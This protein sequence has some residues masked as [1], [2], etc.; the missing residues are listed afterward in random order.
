MSEQQHNDTLAN[1][2]NTGINSQGN[3]SVSLTGDIGDNY[4]LAD[5]RDDMDFYHFQGGEGDRIEWKITADGFPWYL[6]DLVFGGV[7]YNA[8]GN[9]IQSS[10][11][12]GSGTY[13]FILPSNGLYYLAVWGGLGRPSSGTFA[14]VDPNLFPRSIGNAVRTGT[15]TLSLNLFDNTPNYPSPAP[16]SVTLAVSPTSVTEDGTPNLVYTFTRSGSTTNTLAVNYTIGGTATNGSD[17]TNIGTSVTFAAGSSTATVTVAPTADTTVENDE[18]VILT[19]AS[20]TGYTVGST[21]AVTGTITNDDVAALPSIS[22][23]VS[24][25]SVQEDGTSNLVYTFTRTGATTSAITANYTVGGT[26]TLGTDYTGISSSSTTKTVSFA[27]GSTTAI[28]TVDPTADTTVESDETVTLTLASGTGYTVGTTGAVTGT[29][30]NDDNVTL[31][32]ITLGVNPASVQEDGTANLV[33]TFSRTGATTSALTVNYSIAGTADATDYTGATPGTGKTIA[34]AAGSSTT[35]V[36]ID[37]TADATLESNE[38]VALTLAT[39]TGYT[40]ATTSAVTGTI[41]NDDTS[42]TL[43]VSPSSVQEDGTS[44]LVYTFT[45]AGI[46]SNALTVNYGV[47][48]TGTF[49]TDYTQ[50]GAASFTATTGTVSF[51]AGSTTATITID[52]T[53]D[54]TVESNETV[55]LTLASGTGYTIATTTAV[56]GTI[57]NDDVALPSISLAVSPAS[58][59]ENGTSNLIYTFTR[60]GATTNALTVNYSVGGAGTFNTDY[61]QTGAASF[62][63]TTGTVNFAA[64][65]ATAIVTVD[66]TADTTVEPDET[67]ALTLATGTGYTIATTSAVT[68]TIA[69]DDTSNFQRITSQSNLVV[70]PGGSLTVPISYSTSTND[71]TLPGIGVRIHYDSTDI[72]F[73]NATSLFAQS[74]F[75]TITDQAD[76]QNFDADSSTDRYLQFQYLDF[77]GNWP[78]QVLPQKLGDFNFSASAN[79]T[80]TQLNLTSPD[81]TTASGYSLKADPILVGKQEWTLD[82]DGNGSVGALSDGL[83]AVRY[84]FGSAFSGNALID[85]AIAPDATRNLTQIQAYLADLT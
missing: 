28:V 61:T 81:G 60:T 63:A 59:T 2:I 46:T 83:I 6:A 21:N 62:T 12:S 7:L 68:G 29:I 18:T 80:G 64:G 65:S 3:T 79:F 22:L 51:A 31:P 39:G 56:T 10:S 16:A 55:A 58:V 74:L 69:N 71:N 13:A 4:F 1:A 67:V 44:N 42:I 11:Q 72:T 23:A 14:D 52:P 48:G 15:Y 50:T 82:I 41:A 19:L 25:V 8:N 33:Y 5:L 37:P 35:T 49:N 47:S 30:A 26:A 34:F 36:T 43:A 32:S 54:T 9:I 77:S 66:P 17:Y 76:T 78:N 45:R 85:G 53:A 24:P 38:T 70:R 40:I 27:A 73:Q 20:G 75:G 84:L 57:A